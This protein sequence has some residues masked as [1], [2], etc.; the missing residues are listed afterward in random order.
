MR[1]V[2]DGVKFEVADQGSGHVV[3]LLH[4]FPDSAK[5][6]GVPASV[7]LCLRDGTAA[8]CRAQLADLLACRSLYTSLSALPAIMFAQMR[9]Q[10][11]IQ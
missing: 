9:S 2:V 4:G 11:G 1:L 10:H 8:D 3:L 7:G 5:L 6:W